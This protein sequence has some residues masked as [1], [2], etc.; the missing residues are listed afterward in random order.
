MAKKVS[1]SVD[2]DVY[3]ELIKRAGGPRK[4]SRFLA[5]RLRALLDEADPVT[6]TVEERLAL[7]EQKFHAL[8]AQTTPPRPAARRLA[9][10]HRHVSGRSGRRANLRP[11]A[12]DP[13]GRAPRV[14]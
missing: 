5:P 8:A 11:G 7:L 4:L 14:I 12:G 2:E 6:M 1:L 9:G 3:E 10:D 13:R